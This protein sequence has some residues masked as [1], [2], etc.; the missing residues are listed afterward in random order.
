MLEPNN[1]KATLKCLGLPYGPTVIHLTSFP[2]G[3][4]TTGKN[5]ASQRRDLH[6]DQLVVGQG[7]CSLRI[8]AIIVIQRDLKSG[9]RFRLIAQCP[10]RSQYRAPR[11]PNRLNPSQRVKWADFLAKYNAFT[12]RSF[13][14][15]TWWRVA[16]LSLS[17]HFAFS[18]SLIS[19]KTT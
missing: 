14:N 3:S 16:F 9:V 4:Q 8:D 2:Q 18:W 5:P 11:M 13:L 15:E 12:R 19:N 7:N 10:L 6:H 1:W 17:A